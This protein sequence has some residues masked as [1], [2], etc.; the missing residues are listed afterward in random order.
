MG[1]DTPPH[2][3]EVSKLN[4]LMWSEMTCGQRECSMEQVVGTHRVLIMSVPPSCVPTS[5]SGAECGAARWAWKR[6]GVG[7][8]MFKVTLFSL[9]VLP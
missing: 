4:C 3:L 6:E 7:E 2:G 1:A 5:P 8:G 9:S